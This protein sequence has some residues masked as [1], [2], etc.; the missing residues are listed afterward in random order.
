MR[1]LRRELVVRATRFADHDLMLLCVSVQGRPD[2]RALRVLPRGIR[3]PVPKSVQP[4][5]IMNEPDICSAPE[6]G[7]AISMVNLGEMAL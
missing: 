6:K 7:C 1:G 4:I 2:R 5:E 3:D